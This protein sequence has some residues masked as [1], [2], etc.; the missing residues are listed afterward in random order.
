MVQAFLWRHREL[1][2]IAILLAAAWFLFQWG[3][4][5]RIRANEAETGRN[6]AIVDYQNTV[7]KYVNA[8]GDVVTMSRAIS[9]DRTNFKAA[10]ESKELQWIKKFKD[11]KRAQSASS[12]DTFFAPEDNVVVRT[13]YVPCKDSV[14]A[15]KYS[16]I[17]S[18]N[19]IEA[20]VLDTP[21]VE[22]RDKYYVA[23]TK[24]RPKHWFIKLQWSRFEFSG[25]VTNSNKLIKVDSIQTIVVK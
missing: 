13:I 6:A 16:Y 1:V 9:L 24:A 2:A 7:K 11:Y 17:D 12:F 22:I 8:Q 15:W 4:A 25:Q 23:V 18:Y 3:N 19:H 10:L 20:T 5:N 21:R 14:K